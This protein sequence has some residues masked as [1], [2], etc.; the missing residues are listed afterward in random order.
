ME[1][2]G[3]QIVSLPPTH[4][5]NLHWF[6]FL[7]FLIF[8]FF[9]IKKNAHLFTHRNEN[10]ISRLCSPH[11]TINHVPILVVLPFADTSTAIG[12]PIDWMTWPPAPDPVPS[13]SNRRTVVVRDHEMSF[14]VPSH[15]TFGKWC[16]EDLVFGLWWV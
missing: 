7:F 3:S 9:F 4:T 13:R 12:F 2:L 16:E 6:L 11:W 8:F 14:S 10:P 1:S 15:L 5:P